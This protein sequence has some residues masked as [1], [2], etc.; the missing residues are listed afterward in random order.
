MN[1]LDQSQDITLSAYIEGNNQ[2][3]IILKNQKVSNSIQINKRFECDFVVFSLRIG[4]SIVKKTLQC[5]QMAAQLQT[6]ES[7]VAAAKLSSLIPN[8]NRL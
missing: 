6:T 4:T 3:L 2:Q 1:N 8:L 5:E 7:N